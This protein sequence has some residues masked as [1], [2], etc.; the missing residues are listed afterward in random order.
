MVLAG[1]PL[2]ALPATLLASSRLAGALAGRLALPGAVDA[3]GVDPG[4]GRAGSL[5]VGPLG[6]VTRLGAKGPLGVGD[7]VAAPVLLDLGSGLAPGP[8]TPDRLRYGAQGLQDIAR[9]LLLDGESGG[10]RCQ[11]NV[12][13]ISR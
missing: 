4:D 12:L 10:A 8:P 13:T 5:P 9:A 3:L 1:G 6:W 2:R 11:A 7:L